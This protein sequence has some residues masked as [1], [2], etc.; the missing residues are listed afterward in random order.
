MP[1]P[2]G[3]EIG[4]E[5]LQKYF[6]TA[7]KASKIQLVGF[8]DKLKRRADILSSIEELTIEQKQIEQEIKMF[9]K[10]NEL[11]EN[12]SYKVTWRNVDTTRLD[13]KR[14]R[15]EKPDIYNTYAKTSSSRRFQIKAA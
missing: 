9:M 1:N 7:K 11:A 12:D 6:K 15:E 8:D 3:S 10:D 5:L 4:D 13:T 2:A 14:I